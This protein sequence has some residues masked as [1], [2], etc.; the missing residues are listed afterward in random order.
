MQ[1]Q[2]MRPA[3][4][5]PCEKSFIVARRQ[6]LYGHIPEHPQKP[7]VNALEKPGHFNLQYASIAHEA[8][9]TESVWAA[10]PDSQSLRFW[11][12]CRWTEPW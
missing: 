9:E 2:S 10:S 1:A 8:K 3:T 7:I 11:R 12:P 5:D 4:I 6:E